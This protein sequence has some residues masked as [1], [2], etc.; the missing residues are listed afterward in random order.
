[1]AKQSDTLQW[2]YLPL[3]LDSLGSLSRGV[4][5]SRPVDVQTTVRCGPLLYTHE[6]VGLN[7]PPLLLVYSA[8]FLVVAWPMASSQ[9]GGRNGSRML[10]TAPVLSVKIVRAGRNLS[11]PRPAAK[12]GEKAAEAFTQHSSQRKRG[13]TAP[14]RE[15]GSGS[16]STCSFVLLCFEVSLKRSQLKQVLGINRVH[17]K[18]EEQRR[19]ERSSVT[20]PWDRGSDGRELHDKQRDGKGSYRWPKDDFIAVVPDQCN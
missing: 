16:L 19:E 13:P 5:F 14:W 8:T 2:H 20:R 4:T 18:P 12:R 15:M 7:F 3:K 9:W 1:M 10:G 11:A 17:Q 6:L